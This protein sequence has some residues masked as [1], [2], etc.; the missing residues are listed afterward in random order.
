MT[1]RSAATELVRFHPARYTAVVVT[2]PPEATH[3]PELPLLILLGQYLVVLAAR[4]A[5]E[6]GTAAAVAAVVASS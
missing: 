3:R 1:I 5:E 4:D 2:T 6:A